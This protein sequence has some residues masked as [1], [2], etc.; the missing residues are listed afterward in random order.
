MINF[1]LAP[2]PLSRETQRERAKEYLSK[3]T[4]EELKELLEEIK[5]E[6]K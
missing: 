3:L 5:K 1:K 4:E 6:K 2:K